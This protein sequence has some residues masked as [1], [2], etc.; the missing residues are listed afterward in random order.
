MTAMNWLARQLAWEHRLV[1]LR[2]EGRPTN[3]RSRTHDT[4]AKASQKA[5]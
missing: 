5:A 4:D 3:L 2:S 1:E